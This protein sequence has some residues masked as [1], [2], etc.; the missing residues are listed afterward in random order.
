MERR[1]ASWGNMGHPFALFPMLRNWATN[2]YVR[3]QIH[4]KYSSKRAIRQQKRATK[5]LLMC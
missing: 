3:Q 2:S 4:N 5:L 1:G